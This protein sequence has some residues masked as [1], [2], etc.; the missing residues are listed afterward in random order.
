MFESLR[1]AGPITITWCLF[2]MPVVPYHRFTHGSCSSNDIMFQYWFLSH[3]NIYVRNIAK[4]IA[5]EVLL[6]KCIFVQSLM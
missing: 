4:T 3:H 6:S 1:S 2:Q 5:Q